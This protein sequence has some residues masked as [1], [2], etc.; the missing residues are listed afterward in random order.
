[1]LCR[2]AL[3]STIAESRISFR[4]RG[5]QWEKWWKKM[6]EKWLTKRKVTNFEKKKVYS[7]EMEYFDAKSRFWLRNFLTFTGWRRRLWYY[8]RMLDYWIWENFY[9]KGGFNWVII[10]L[11]KRSDIY[12]WGF[13]DMILFNIL[14]LKICTCGN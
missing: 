8:R 13:Y 3:Y 4:E 9:T 1:M 10:F 6:S 7:K 11:Y 2:W 14:G 5:V 12:F